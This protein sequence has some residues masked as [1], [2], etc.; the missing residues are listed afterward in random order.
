MVP[1]IDHAVRTGALDVRVGL[2]HV[3]AD[4]WAPLLD[5]AEESEPSRYVGNNGWVVAALQAA[6]S[7]ISAKSGLEAGVVRAVRGV[8]TPT[9][10]RRSPARCWALPTG[11][12][13]CHC[14]GGA[15]CMDGRGCVPET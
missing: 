4:C 7:A 6:W 12:A 9:P 1:V 8:A 5:E 2:P 10:S 11:A 14:V 13:P 15:F 3:E